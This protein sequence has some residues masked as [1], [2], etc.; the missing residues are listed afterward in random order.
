[1]MESLSV[2]VEPLNGKADELRRTGHT[3]MFVAV[4]SGAAG[5]VGVADPVKVS[6]VSVIGNALRLKRA[7]L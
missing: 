6:S 5:L 7:T 3:V 4:D 2:S 1:M